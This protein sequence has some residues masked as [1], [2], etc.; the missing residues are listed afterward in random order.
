[1]TLIPVPVCL[2]CG[3]NLLPDPLEPAELRCLMCGR[4]ESEIGRVVRG[5]GPLRATVRVPVHKL[6]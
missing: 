4:T 3:G 6:K 5:E 2:V 1:M